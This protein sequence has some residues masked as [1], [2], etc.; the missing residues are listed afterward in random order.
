M[1]VELG[2]LVKDR[3]TGF[4]G[5]VTSVHSFLDAA[6]R[7][8]VQPRELQLGQPQKKQ[9]F[10]A[11]DLKVLKKRVVKPLKPKTIK[12]ELGD[13]VRDSLTIFT[14]KL[15]AVGLYINGCRNWSVVSV[16]L[17]DGEIIEE[18]LSESRLVK[19]AAGPK[20]APVKTAGPRHM[21][22]DYLQ[23]PNDA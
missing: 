2:D 20:T 13:H 3:I 23:E 15:S 22:A 7:F 11:V 18:D 14:G 1:A 6:Q 12:F 4:E 16:D 10:D 5:V 8:M 9:A 19:V 17:H 21:A